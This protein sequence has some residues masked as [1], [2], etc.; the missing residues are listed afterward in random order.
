MLFIPAEPRPFAVVMALTAVSLSAACDGTE[1]TTP[2]DSPEAQKLTI[3]TPTQP[4]SAAVYVASSQGFFSDQGL[5]VEI[6][7]RPTGETALEELIAGRADLATTAETPVVHAALRGDTVLVLATIATTR[8]GLTV[9]G[10]RDRGVDEPAD[11][12]GKRIG[13]TR[14]TN[15]EYFLHLFLAH[16]RIGLDSVEILDIP[17]AGLG[18]SLTEGDVDAILWWEPH[19]SRLEEQL[20]ANASQFGAPSLYTWFWNVVA[21][22]RL[23][24][25]RPEAVRALIRALRDATTFTVS[26]PAR[27]R[28]I[29]ASRLGLDPESLERAWEQTTFSLSLDQALLLTMEDQ[30]RWVEESRGSAPVGVP[31]FLSFIE[32]LPLSEV[33]PG[34]VSVLGWGGSD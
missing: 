33:A 16:H 28:A 30:A 11:L 18:S 24:E 14:G 2:P 17:P 29:V 7:S 6:V 22:P 15:V 20:G 34:A 12:A 32:T 3:V 27:T 8:R 5:E 4:I 21:S 26:H 25:R 9:M 10:R 19:R 31:N 13:V 23:V 1:E